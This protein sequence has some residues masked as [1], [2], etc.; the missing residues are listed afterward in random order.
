MIRKDRHTVDQFLDQDSAFVLCGLSPYLRD[1]KVPEG[2]DN[3]IETKRQIVTKRSL[4]G[5]LGSLSSDCLDLISHPTLLLSERLWTDLVLVP[6]PDH[7]A[8]PQSGTFGLGGPR[9]L[10]TGKSPAVA[11]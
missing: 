2:L 10:R 7:F 9:D 3:L 8:L 1:I 4:R 11:E 5:L 6:D